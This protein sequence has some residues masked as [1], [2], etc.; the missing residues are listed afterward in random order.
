MSDDSILFNRYGRLRSGWRAGIFVCIFLVFTLL[1]SSVIATLLYASGIGITRGPAYFA[2]SSLISLV[3]ALLIGW[4]CAKHLERLPFSSL[5]AL[6]KKTWF[7]NFVFG[8]AIAA[9]S[10]ALAVL[11]AAVFGDLR[12][13]FN[14]EAS[15]QDLTE[16]LIFS[17]LVFA[18]AAAFEE[19]LFRGYIL[20]T[21]SR[22]GL[23]WF[24][25]LVTALFFATVHLAN[26][27]AG[28]ISSL[29][30]ALAGIWFGI[31]YLKTRDLWLPFG[32]HLSWNWVQ[33]SILGIEVSGLTDIAPAPLMQ[34]ID[35]G[36]YWL[37][38]GEYGIEGGLACTAALIA[39]CLT[40]YWIPFLR[41]TPELL[42]FSQHEIPA[43]STEKNNHPA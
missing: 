43:R 1:A 32:A 34:E 3:L 29:N 7:R 14:N 35:G 2:I 5:G 8:I 9:F 25:I 30:T 39:T 19:A 15:G 42:A 28:R 22:A 6:P 13:R 23:A 40:T 16:T 24:A 31:A 20:Q 37:T 27:G 36:P 38:G 10:L 12:F 17:L 33:G 11:L 21:F 4:L 26:P 41:P 18:V